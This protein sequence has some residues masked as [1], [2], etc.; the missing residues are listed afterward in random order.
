MPERT[1]LDFH[2]ETAGGVPYRVQAGYPTIDCE[3]DKVTAT[4]VYLI[5]ANKIGD[6]YFESMPGVRLLDGKLMI[7]AGRALPGTNFITTKSIKFAPWQGDAFGGDPFEVDK[8]ELGNAAW[9]NTYSQYYLATITYETSQLDE[10][11]DDQDPN[12]T[13]PET[14]LEHSVS[15]GGQLLATQ[16]KNVKVADQPLSENPGYPDLDDAYVVPEAD[17]LE[18]KDPQLPITRLIPGIEHNLKWKFVLNPD[19]ATIRA[20]LGH[21]NNKAVPLF[22]DAPAETVMFTGVS[23]S[24]QFLWTGRLLRPGLTTPGQVR[25]KPWSLDFKFSERYVI[26]GEAEYGWNHV[27]S[28]TKQ[29][30]VRL[31]RPDGTGIYR[32]A[33]LLDVFQSVSLI[34]N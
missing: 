17:R 3:E 32:T 16:P 5:P 30:W 28:P 23:G 34:D 1:D 33:N 4:E 31:A 2:L 19:W 18:N 25:V 24:Q 29:K 10:D 12:E 15:V 14:F 11:D 20:R 26:E 27:F 8:D 7:S 21:L 13:N 22:F 6:F 9:L